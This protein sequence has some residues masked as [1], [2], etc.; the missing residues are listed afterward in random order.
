MKIYSTIID[1]GKD[2]YKTF[3][4]AK[5]K[6]ELL[7]VY[8]GNGEF[9][10]IKDITKEYQVDANQVRDTLLKGGFGLVEADL[11]FNVIMNSLENFYE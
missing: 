11:V 3:A 9:V 1:D 8:G 7:K 5:N 10:K 6:N 4:Y 2:V